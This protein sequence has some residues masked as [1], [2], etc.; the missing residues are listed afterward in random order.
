MNIKA[1]VLSERNSARTTARILRPAD[2]RTCGT[3]QQSHE[4]R[5]LD[6]SIAK[7][8]VAQVS[9]RLSDFIIRCSGLIAAEHRS[10]R[11]EPCFSFADRLIL[12]QSP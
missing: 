12:G 5:P 4:L 3:F 7:A 2:G 6:L 9:S 10:G 1:A 11:P 8:Q